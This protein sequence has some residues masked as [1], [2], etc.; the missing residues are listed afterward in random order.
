MCHNIS[1]ET[2]F[3]QMLPTLFQPRLRCTCG[4][5]VCG[6]SR[7]KH[8]GRRRAE[9]RRHTRDCQL[10]E[11]VHHNAGVILPRPATPAAPDAMGDEQISLG[12]KP[13]DRPVLREQELE[14]FG[15]DVMFPATH[16]HSQYMQDRVWTKFRAVPVRTRVSITG[17][18]E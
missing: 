16:L 18:R 14:P 3:L 7:S 13:A 10:S 11:Q 17:R 8:V 6:C 1:R 9:F 2:I 4:H 5:Q 15:C 12:S